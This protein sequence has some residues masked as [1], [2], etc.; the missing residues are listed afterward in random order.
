MSKTKLFLAG[1]LLATAG[2]LAAQSARSPFSSF[3]VG[4][5]FGN[6]LAHSQGMAGV[7]ISNPQYWYLNN[8]NP[9]L[10]V[11]NNLTTFEGGLMGER[12]SISNSE[13]SE[14][15]T[16][17]NMTY[18]ILG[19]PIKRGRWSNSIGLMPY[20]TVN[21][22]FSY[23]DAINGSTNTVRVTE[24]GTGGIN[25]VSWSHGV[26]L[27]KYFSV[28][29]R[30][31]YLFSAIENRYT[32]RLEETDQVAV[33]TP[34][35]YQRYSYSDFSFTGAASF[36]IDSLFRKNY[37]LNIGVV[38]DWKATVD[39]R[40]F[41][42]LEMRNV[43]G[44]IDST[45]LRNNQPGKTVMPP[46]LQAGI[47][48]GRGDRWVVGID[49]AVVDFTQFEVGFN[50]QTTT[51]QRGR[52]IAVGAEYTPNPVSLGNY[53]KRITYRTG[54]SFEEAPYLINGNPVNDFGIN[55]GLST[56]VSRYSSLDWAF[57]WGKRGSISENGIAE[58]YF[59]IYFGV[60]FNDQWF[61]KRRFD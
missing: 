28:G 51:F 13:L 31:N 32:N 1:I 46:L 38:Y 44:V 20:S 47:S 60:T 4:D 36:H 33:F 14:S 53:L 37:R 5:Y 43:L 22:K 27:H 35:V 3:G 10:L 11:F 61:I 24:E 34:S 15:N 58:N 55:F 6:A 45:V 39:T 59:K 57:R 52:K 41:E 26:A 23:S 50:Q 21:Y 19:F 25:Q 30:A 9:A 49:G 2:Q 54:V 16:N 42:T 48:F 7:G 56:P 29:A 8:Q 18:L 17:G 12:K 40:L